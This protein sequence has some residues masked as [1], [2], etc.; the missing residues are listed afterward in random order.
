MENN[1]LSLMHLLKRIFTS[2]EITYHL[3]KIKEL[4]KERSFQFWN[5]E[6]RINPDSS[7]Y[8]SKTEGRSPKYFRNYQNLI[9]SFKSL[10]DD[11]VNPRKLLKNHSNLKSDLGKIKKEIQNQY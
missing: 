11:N 10:N 9:D 2:T 4:I 6:K 3:K 1:W 5:L 7:I 8:K